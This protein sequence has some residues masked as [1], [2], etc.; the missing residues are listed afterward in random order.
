M[1]I[2][3][4]TFGH[5][6]LLCMRVETL[7]DVSALIQTLKIR[8]S[9]RPLLSMTISVRQ[10]CIQVTYLGVIFILMIHCGMVKVVVQLAIAVHS[11]PHHGSVNSCLSQLVMIWKYDSA[12]VNTDILP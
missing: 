8:L 7:M 5:L 1:E 9:R 12:G 3:D 6:L 10:E 2:L 11:T 4:N